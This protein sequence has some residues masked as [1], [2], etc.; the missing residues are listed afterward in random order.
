VNALLALWLWMPADTVTTS[1][2]HGMRCCC[3]CTYYT[4]RVTPFASD[5]LS[6]VDLWYEDAF[7]YQPKYPRWR[8]G[9]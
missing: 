6:H 8:A 1:T 2:A 9:K 5:T 4:V 3:P 7:K